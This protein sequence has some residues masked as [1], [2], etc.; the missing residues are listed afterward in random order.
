MPSGRYETLA[1][2]YTWSC[3][4]RAVGIA[5]ATVPLEPCLRHAK[6]ASSREERREVGVVALA[7]AR[8]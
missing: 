3:G 1:Y 8:R 4:C 7:A 5:A 2:T 6:A